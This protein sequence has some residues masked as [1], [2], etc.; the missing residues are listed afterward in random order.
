MILWE[1]FELQMQRS[2]TELKDVWVE[3]GERSTPQFWT[4]LRN[5]VQSWTAQSF[6]VGAPVA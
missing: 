3:P 2:S 6:V 1:F 4:R 5:G